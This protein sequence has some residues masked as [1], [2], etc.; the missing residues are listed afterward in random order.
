MFP[1]NTKWSACTTCLI[2]S[3][4]GSSLLRPTPAVWNMSA[5]PAPSAPITT[6]VRPGARDRLS[7]ASRSSIPPT[8]F[9][10]GRRGATSSPTRIGAASKRPT[11]APIM[12][13]TAP[14]G[15]RGG[16]QDDDLPA[17]GPERPQ[18]ADVRP[19]LGDRHRQCVVDQEQAD[20]HRPGRAHQEADL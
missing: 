4:T 17:G 14:T 7:N 12:P 16:E 19:P 6:P 15:G 20:D 1:L 18:D 13:P 8:A 2:Q 5:T 9:T 3:T 11:R 10:T